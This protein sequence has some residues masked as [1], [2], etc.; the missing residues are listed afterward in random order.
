MKIIFFVFFFIALLFIGGI[1]FLVI[2][3]IR[4]SLRKKTNEEH[5]KDRKDMLDALN[6]AK[7]KLVDW[8]S[9]HLS[10]ISNY[11]DYTFKKLTS[12]YFN[13]FIKGTDNSY[14]LAFRRLDHGLRTD[15]RIMVAS[16]KFMIYFEYVGNENRIYYNDRYI[17]KLVNNMF[18]YN[19]RGRKVGGITRFSKKSSP[20]YQ[21]QHNGRLLAQV[22]KNSD[23]REM[24]SNPFHEHHSSSPIEKPAFIQKNVEKFGKMVQVER[25]LSDEE[26]QLVLAL[27]LFE[28]V[29]YSLDFTM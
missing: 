12:R 8:E 7:A 17:G 24:V 19:D 1:T 3:V 2:R 13:G 15:S 6:L 4:K 16:S 14:L 28:I 23:Q 10:E 25:Q 18:L 5:L 22:F 9:D 21:I 27:V 20:T 11:L 29:Y 26:Y